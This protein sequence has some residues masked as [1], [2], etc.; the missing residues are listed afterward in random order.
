MTTITN[1]CGDTWEG[2][3]MIHVVSVRWQ[4]HGG[5]IGMDPST[6]LPVTV[7]LVQCSPGKTRLTSLWCISLHTLRC[8]QSRREEWCAQT[9]KS[10]QSQWT[11]QHSGGLS[12]SRASELAKMSYH[13]TVHYTSR[14][15]QR[16]AE[17][18]WWLQQLK[19]ATD[20]TRKIIVRSLWR[21]SAAR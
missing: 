7:S 11:W 8:Q 5:K 13:P 6:C 1:A 18:H 9:V 19:W 2:H 12:E 4:L 14:L 17:R 15:S 16:T 20:P 10:A 3:G 21:Q